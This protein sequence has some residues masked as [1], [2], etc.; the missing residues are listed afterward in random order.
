MIYLV[1]CRSNST[2]KIGYSIKPDKRVVALQTSNAFELELV[3]FIDGSVDDERKLHE[4]FKEFRLSGEWFLYS[5]EIK[6]FF[7][8]DSDGFRT[9]YNFENM[10]KITSG[11]NHKVLLKMCSMAEYN[12]GRIILS[13][14]VRVEIMQLLGISSS[15]LSRSL[16]DLK[17][18][19]FITG[20]K[21]DY[22]LNPLAFWRGST[23][24][25]EKI[26]LQLEGFQLHP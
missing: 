12:T 5:R 26:L 20:D 15:M 13:T 18:L 6:E 19:R 25:R 10:F 4:K 22:Y 7:N 2:C 8:D 11:T 23:K 9:Y 1:V 16:A 14:S 17:Q 24:G 3:T 21:G